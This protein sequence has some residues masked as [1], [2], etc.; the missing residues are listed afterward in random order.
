MNRCNEKAHADAG[1]VSLVQFA[2]AN[3]Q[4]GMCG[5]SPKYLPP[6]LMK[7]GWFNHEPTLFVSIYVFVYSG[8]CH[9]MFSK[10]LWSNSSSISAIKVLIIYLTFKAFPPFAYIVMSSITAR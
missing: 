9:V 2:Q 3:S 10:L 6:H 4:T 7:K 5:K 8:I 1:A